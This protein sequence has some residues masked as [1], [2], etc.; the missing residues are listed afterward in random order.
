MSVTSFIITVGG[1]KSSRMANDV[2]LGRLE[3][4]AGDVFLLCYG[5]E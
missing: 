1:G 5:L 4:E 2:F 3:S